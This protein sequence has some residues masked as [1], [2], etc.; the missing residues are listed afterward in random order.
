MMNL[1][2]LYRLLTG[3]AF[4]LYG[5]S[6]PSSGSNSGDLTNA[7]LQQGQM[8]SDIAAQQTA[9]NRPNQV[10]PWG[11]TNWSSTLGTDP[12]TGAPITNW[13]QTQTLDPTLQNA[14]TQQFGLQGNRTNLASSLLGQVAGATSQ[15]F[16]WGAAPAMGGAVGPQQ[17][18]G[19]AIQGG[20]AMP[21]QQTSVDNN[22]GQINTQGAAQTTQTTNEPA[23][24]AQRDQITQSLMDRMVPQQQRDTA[25]MESKLA[26]MGLP[27]GS[28]AYNREKNRMEQNQSASR[29]DAMNQAGNEQARMQQALLAQQQQA[30]GQDASSRAAGNQALGQQFGQNLQSGQFGNAAL[31]NIF[32]QN[33]GAGAFANQAAGQQFQQNLG[34]N[35]QNYS[36]QMQSSQYENQRRQQALAEQQAARGMSLNEMNALLSGQQVGS[37]QMPNFTSAQGSAQAPN[38]LGAAQ[39][40]AQIN[41]NQQPDWGT[42]LGTGLGA[43]LGK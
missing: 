16:D 20:I 26:N 42:L 32:G 25:A 33:T 19:T 11:S 22:A 23:F 30:Y 6:N 2:W 9:A 36:Q 27:M 10:T 40:Q 13:T 41:A 17:T 18:T 12:A 15:P 3:E 37:P 24:A 14:L 28:E 1:K 34:Q 29:Y 39:T 43:W 8:S 38:L 31:Q 5:G 35:A 21:G 7:A 4:M